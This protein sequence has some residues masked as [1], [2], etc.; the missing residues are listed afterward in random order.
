MDGLPGMKV[1]HAEYLAKAQDAR[2]RAEAAKEPDM[3]RIWLDI[4]TNWQA[5]AEQLDR[6]L[7]R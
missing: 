5:L 3:R 1:R 4:A 2:A 6:M 7:K